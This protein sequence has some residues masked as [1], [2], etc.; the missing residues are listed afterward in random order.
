MAFTLTEVRESEPTLTIATDPDTG[1]DAIIE[2]PQASGTE[3]KRLA[4]A[5]R[6]GTLI[7]ARQHTVGK[8]IV[9]DDGT[10]KRDRKSGTE[11]V[12]K[13]TADLADIRDARDH[14]LIA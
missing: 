7:L 9:Q 10:R 11:Q 2:V 14:G 4:V 3:P 1:K 8:L 5:I 6:S 13:A 12:W